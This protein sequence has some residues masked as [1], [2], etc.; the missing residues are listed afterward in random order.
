MAFNL[1]N[2]YNH[3]FFCIEV[4]LVNIIGV[5]P[6]KSIIFKTRNQ[7]MEYYSEQIN[8]PIILEIGVFKGEFLEYINT[9]CSTAKIDAVDLFEGIEY[10]CDVDGNNLVYCDLGKSY[11]DLL[12]KYR[13]YENINIFKSDSITFLKKQENEKYDIIYIDADHSFQAVKDDL[14]NAYD[15]IKN[16]GYLM[17][18][19]YAINIKKARSFRKFGVKKAVDEFCK[20]YNQEV[21]AFALDGYISFCIKINKN[22]YYENMNTKL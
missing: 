4:I 21:L 8:N 16:G 11:L 20:K 17:G 1:K 3:L 5:I 18:H 12:D 6:K 9:K 2:Y 13:G 15:K 14:I 22:N 10:S 7:M 19:D